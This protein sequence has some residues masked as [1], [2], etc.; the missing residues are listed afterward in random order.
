MKAIADPAGS[1]LGDDGDHAGIV[2]FRSVHTGAR[3]RLRT[4]SFDETQAAHSL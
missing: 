3:I 1:H 2:R 4:G